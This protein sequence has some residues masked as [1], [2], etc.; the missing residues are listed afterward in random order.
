M[1]L[2]LPRWPC[3]STS[4]EG[5]IQ[6]L[7]QTGVVRTFAV[8]DAMKR[9]DRAC[10]VPRTLREDAYQ[11]SPCPIGFNQTISAPHTHAHVLELAHSTLVG[12]AEPRVLD[13]GAGSGYL[14][15]ALA[16]LV[17]EAGGR[18]FGL[19]LVPALAQFA[20]KNAL[21]AAGDLMKRGVISLHC[22]NGWNGLPSEAP[23]NFIFVGAAVSSPPQSL[24]DQLA[25]G[26]QLVVP[27]DDPRGGQA[28]VSVTRH[29]SSFVHRRIM[30]ACFVPLI[31]GEVVKKRRRLS[32]AG[33]TDPSGTNSSRAT[34]SFRAVR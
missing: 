32:V 17:D 16:S 18:V 5:L 34:Y 11:D 4:N 13:I 21:R 15:V 3:S 14:T 23:F 31:R 22:Q 12:V 19:E 26:G 24:L 33:D 6:N 2:S 30:P 20:R 28:L 27:V 25:D 10:F 8:A 29:G 7:M 1:A 9:T